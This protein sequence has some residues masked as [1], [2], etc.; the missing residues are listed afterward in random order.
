MVIETLEKMATPTGSHVFKT[1]QSYYFYDH[2]CL[3][4]LKSDE[5]FP[6]KIFKVFLATIRP[7][8]HIKI[9]SAKF[10]KN[11]AS[12]LVMS[13]KVIAN[14]IQLTINDHISSHC[15][16][17]SGELIISITRVEIVS[18][19]I[20]LCLLIVTSAVNHRK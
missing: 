1:D 13:F 17:V 3:I 20:T 2:F 9:N 12:N 15:A 5:Q 19:A 18:K 7:E 10:G 14:N 11:P 6:E 16:Y 8:G 4:F